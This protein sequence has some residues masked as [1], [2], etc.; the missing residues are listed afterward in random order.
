MQKGK[1]RACLIH[2]GL[3][4]LVCAIH[5]RVDKRGGCSFRPLGR[6]V[7]RLVSCYFE[8]LTARTPTLESDSSD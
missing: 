8:R 6:T 3:P 2:L 4:R 1:S 5:S 7:A